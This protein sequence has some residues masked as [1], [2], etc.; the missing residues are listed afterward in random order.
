MKK[1]ERVSDKVYN[2]VRLGLPRSPMY[3]VMWSPFSMSLRLVYN[4]VW[5]NDSLLSKRKHQ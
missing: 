4:S 5:H 1:M 2:Q 3:E